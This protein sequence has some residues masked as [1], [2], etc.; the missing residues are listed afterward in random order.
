MGVL[1]K[2]KDLAVS[3]ERKNN[4]I[5]TY[6]VEKQR[7]Y[8][9]KFRE[10]KDNIER[11]YF[12]YRCQMKLNNPL[13]NVFLNVAALPILIF[14]Y[15]TG[16]TKI[17]ARNKVDAVFFSDGK[18]ENIIPIVLKKQYDDWFV[19]TEKG[20]FLSNKDKKFFMQLIRRYPFSW[21]FLLKCLIKIR[22][23]SYEIVTKQPR[24][25]V[26][27]SE[28]SFTSS[29]LT[30]YC[31]MYNVEHIN[32]MHGEKL[33]YMRDSFF[34]FNRCY[35]WSRYYQ[36]LL[37]ELKAEN[38]QFCIA[39]PP[40]LKFTED[41]YREKVFDYTYY[42]GAERDER[43]KRIIVC[44]GNLVQRGYHVSVRPHPR[45]SDIDMVRKLC[46]GIVSVED[47]C[48]FSIEESILQT[49]NVVSCYSTV[50]NQAHYNNIS[51]VI[52]D[53]SEPKEYAKLKEL[54]YVML[55]ENHKLLSQVM[56][57]IV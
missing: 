43:L 4:S 18:P 30:G 51:I 28:Y 33:Y 21:F 27:C 22:F 14:Y 13:L 17:D 15:K 25:I 7:A 57:E 1:G 39:I 42:L 23:Y 19:V 31:K 3:L 16:F 47:V 56:E 44:M 26:V 6:P 32:V 10:P 36:D 9:E 40:S 29:M 38:S 45:Y 11:S 52:D 12:Q 54:G 53:I 46:D 20:E 35:V 50:L 24:A 55:R 48:T 49:R 2:L 8:L 34:H 5:F 41:I 37:C